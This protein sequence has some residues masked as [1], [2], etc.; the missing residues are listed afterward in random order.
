VG[1]AP[2]PRF[3]AGT[4]IR[5]GPGAGAGW[6]EQCDPMG[7]RGAM[8][9][10]GWGN[11]SPGRKRRGLKGSEIRRGASVGLPREETNSRRQAA[12]PV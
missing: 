7:L 2:G 10:A 4:P 8:R 6:G 11:A 9:L 3:L 12:F 5:M 1:G